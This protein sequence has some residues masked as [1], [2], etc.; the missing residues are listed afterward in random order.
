[1]KAHLYT[2]IRLFANGDKFFEQLGI[3]REEIETVTERATE[4]LEGA[5][6]I[7]DDQKAKHENNLDFLYAIVQN[8]IIDTMFAGKNYTEQDLARLIEEVRTNWEDAEFSDEE[9]KALFDEAL[10]KTMSSEDISRGTVDSG[11]GIYEINSVTNEIRR[12]QTKDIQK[13][14]EK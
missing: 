10:S 8:D 6:E 12:T 14:Q 9:F 5:I 13:D 4:Y 1:M 11:T 7:S 2:K 3:P